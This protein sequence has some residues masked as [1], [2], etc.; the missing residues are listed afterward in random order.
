MKCVCVCVCVY[1]CM[2]LC[3]FVFVLVL[4]VCVSCR[5]NTHTHTHTQTHT[6][7]HKHTPHISTFSCGGASGG[8][9][10][11]ALG[12]A[13]AVAMMLRPRPRHAPFVR[14]AMSVRCVWGREKLVVDGEWVMIMCIERERKVGGG[15]GVWGGGASKREFDTRE[16][17]RTW[18]R[19]WQRERNRNSALAVPAL[20]TS[21]SRKQRKQRA[22]HQREKTQVQKCECR[23]ERERERERMQRHFV[24]TPPAAS[25]NY[26]SSASSVRL[27]LLVRDAPHPH[28]HKMHFYAAYKA[29][30]TRERLHTWRAQRA[31]GL[32]RQDRVRRGHQEPGHRR[33]TCALGHHALELV[34]VL[35]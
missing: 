28:R 15:V 1:V 9:A 4:C 14:S 18:K 33:H 16:K 31:C 29:T 23:R 27:S 6:H 7:T 8:A 35:N 10:A 24:R 32:K 3:V 25:T 19:E 5:A 21:I 2:C 17:Q 20:T 30:T 34:Q 26:T 13:A 22:R 12:G 11:V